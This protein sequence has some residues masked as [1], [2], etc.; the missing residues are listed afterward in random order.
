MVKQVI[1]FAYTGLDCKSF[2]LA[3]TLSIVFIMNQLF[4]CIS[5]F[6]YHPY[7]HN[8]IDL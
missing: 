5:V 4:Y 1:D 7:M 3:Q 2:K 6:L 8:R